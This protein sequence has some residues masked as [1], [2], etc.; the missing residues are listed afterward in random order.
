[1]AKMIN[2]VSEVMRNQEIRPSKLIC[3][4]ATC[5]TVELRKNGTGTTCGTVELCK[6]RTGT[7]WDTVEM[8]HSTTGPHGFLQFCWE[9]FTFL[10]TADQC[11]VTSSS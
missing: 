8:P 6:N 10:Y 9:E 5:G 2:N 3:W 7:T 4:T 1:M 11:L